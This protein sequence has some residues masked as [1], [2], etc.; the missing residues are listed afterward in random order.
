MTFQVET[1][2]DIILPVPLVQH[3]VPPASNL[4]TQIY[5]S[6]TGYDP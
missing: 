2:N 3:G 5:N 6:D 1:H 4:R